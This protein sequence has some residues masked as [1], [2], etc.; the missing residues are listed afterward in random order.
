MSDINKSLE[1]VVKVLVAAI[2]G[3]LGLFVLGWVMRGLGGLFLGVAGL[4]IALLK[5]IVPVAV[6]AGIVY[7]AVSQLRPKAP[8]SNESSRSSNNAVTAT[9][10]IEVKHD[11][12]ASVHPEPVVHPE[13]SSAKQTSVATSPVTIEVEAPKKD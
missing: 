3:I 10:D 11:H 4:L 9:V 8:E 5:F 13:V 7:F 6:I 2:G 1:L 12:P